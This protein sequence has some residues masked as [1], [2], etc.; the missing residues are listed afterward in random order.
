MTKYVRTAV[1]IAEPMNEFNFLL[2]YPGE[3]SAAG[4][5]GPRTIGHRDGYKVIDQDG[6]VSWIEKEEFERNHKKLNGGE[7]C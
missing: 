1:V 2:K 3:R 6:S 7:E 5:I 4:V